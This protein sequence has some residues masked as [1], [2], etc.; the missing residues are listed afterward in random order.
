MGVQVG[1]ASEGIAVSEGGGDKSGGV[2]LGDAVGAGAGKGRVAFKER[3]HVGNC[4]VVGVFDGLRHPRA[5]ISHSAIRWGPRRYRD[6]S[7]LTRVGEKKRL[8]TGAL[9]FTAEDL[10]L[11]LE[12]FCKPPAI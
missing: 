5:T 11:F 6:R 12:S 9:V 7:P 10:K 4:G 1:V 3:Q 8:Q 2:D